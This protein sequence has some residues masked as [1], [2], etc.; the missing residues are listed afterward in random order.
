MV[1][2]R[3]ASSLI[4]LQCALLDHTDWL[5]C[6]STDTQGLL[7]DLLSQDTISILHKVYQLIHKRKKGK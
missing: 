1:R 4:G 5:F 7:G 2:V 3:E 6:H